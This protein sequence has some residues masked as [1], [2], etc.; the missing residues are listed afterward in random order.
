MTPYYYKVYT[1]RTVFCPMRLWTTDIYFC[2]KCRYF[3]KIKNEGFKSGGRFRTKIKCA[4]PFPDKGWF[5][6]RQLNKD[7]P[8]KLK[9]KKLR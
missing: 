5:W 1:K 7:Y 4:Y 2:E 9:V 3:L 8:K 6:K